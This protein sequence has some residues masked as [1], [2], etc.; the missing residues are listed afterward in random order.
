M[1]EQK[2]NEIIQ[3]SQKA[4]K[5]QKE[6]EKQNSNDKKNNTSKNDINNKTN[7]EKEKENINTIKIEKII[8]KKEP[9]INIIKNNIENNN[10]KE[11]KNEEKEIS[12]EISKIS[13][14]SLS[15][16]SKKNYRIKKYKN[17]DFYQ[18]VKYLKRFADYL[19][20]NN[21]YFTIEDKKNF[22]NLMEYLNSKE[23]NDTIQFLKMTNIGNYINYIN[24]KTNIKEFKDLTQKFLDVNKQKIQLQ[25]F[26]ENTLDITEF[27]I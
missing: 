13:S 10:K 22:I 14:L 23:M 1:K 17:F 11:L 20:K 8:P 16:K 26:V 5:E 9:E 12:E 27:N 25:L 6:K 3:E 18:I 4:L 19:D 21:T 24:E 2:E 15:E 7:K